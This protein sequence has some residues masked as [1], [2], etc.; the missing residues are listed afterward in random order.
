MDT[1]SRHIHNDGGLE[2]NIPDMEH[3]ENLSKEEWENLLSDNDRMPDIQFLLAY[4]QAS[5]KN[6]VQ[7]P[8]PNEA[9]Q[10]FRSSRIL[11][12]EEH[13]RRL[14]S[15]WIYGSIAVAAVIAIVV[16]LRVYS[17]NS[18]PRVEGPLV[19]FVAN[20]KS[21]VVTLSEGDEK[22]LAISRS[23]QKS[24]IVVNAQVANYSDA[25][26]PKNSVQTITTPRGKSYKVI[27]NDGTIVLMNADSHLIFPTYFSGKERV[28]KFEGEAYF[29]VSKDSK[30]PFVV[31]TEKVSTRVLGTEFNLKAYASSDTHVTLVEGSVVV[32][33]RAN[34]KKVTLKPGQDAALHN[35]CQF[36]VIQVDTDYY[37]QWKDGFFYFDNMP[38]VEVMK[39]LGRWYNVNIYINDNALLSYRLHFIADRQADINQVVENLNGFSYLSVVYSGNR[40]IISKKE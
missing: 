27:L 1:E 34:N 21:Q 14:R 13:H 24:G 35:D 20:H 7:A 37:I 9:W 2:R 28:V 8:V 33:N 18:T 32:C 3:L 26:V 5:L 30:H 38:L 40:L 36:D 25:S 10:D 4:R 23:I 11:P 39:E 17:I 6:Q 12:A 22:P 29:K 16:I 31:Q 19:A 15:I